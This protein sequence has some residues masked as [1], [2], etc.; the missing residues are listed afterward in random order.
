M[1][2][3]NISVLLTHTMQSVHVAVSINKTSVARLVVAGKTSEITGNVSLCGAVKERQGTR[4]KRKLV[5]NT[6]EYTQST[7]VD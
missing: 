5:E 3:I 6:Y 2:T 4:R 7:D 1:G